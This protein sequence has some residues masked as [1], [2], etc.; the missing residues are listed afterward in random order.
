[1]AA[2]LGAELSGMEFSNA[3][4]LGLAFS[5][6]TKS[7]F[8]NWATFYDA[9]GTP[10]PGAGSSHGRGVIAKTLESQPVFACLDRA[11]DDIHGWMRRSQPNFFLPFD[12]MR[13]DP[14]TQHFA[15]TLRLEGTVCGTGGL[16]FGDETCATSVPGLYAA[17]DAATRELVCGGFTG[18]GGH[19]AAWAMSFGF[20]AGAGAADHARQ[21]ASRGPRTLPHGGLHGGW[22]DGGGT[23]LDANVLIRAMQDEVFSTRR[24]WTRCADLLDDSLA[25][26][27]ALWTRVREA[28]PPDRANRLRV[29]E[30]TAMLAMSRWMYRSASARTETRGMARREEHK[31]VDPQQ[32]HQ[33]LCGGLDEV[34]VNPHAVAWTA[35][36]VAA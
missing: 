6:V 12:R 20:W 26:L 5:S 24:N 17:G 34:W 33:L 32:R 9:S 21:S 13:I 4:G 35:Q 7:L 30:A 27:D 10:I 18:G 8:Y 31:S 23:S 3:Y 11:D 2:E 19:N 28:P 14:F 1:M 36:E 25:R 15:V 29:R 16:N 22:R